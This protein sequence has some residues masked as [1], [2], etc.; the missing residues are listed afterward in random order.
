ME[1]QIDIKPGSHNNCFNQNEH[2]VLPVAVLGSSDLDVYNIAVD[3]LRLQGLAVKVVGKKNNY[4][5][6][7][8]DVNGDG[9]M[10]MIV[11]LE[12]VI[13]YMMEICLEL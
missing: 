1:V 9:I 6:S 11:K 5:A 8:T 13:T 4:L 7:Y 10:D 2:G 3:S 12:D